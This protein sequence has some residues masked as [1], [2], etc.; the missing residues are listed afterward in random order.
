MAQHIQFRKY[1]ESDYEILK[2]MVFA[3]A[4]EDIDPQ[5]TGIAISKAKI[6]GTIQR[7]I[8]HPEQISIRIFEIDDRVAGYALLTFYWSNEYHGVVAILDELYVFQQYRSRGISTQF[9]NHLVQSSEYT[10]L[11]LE[12]FKKNIRAFALY[13]RMGFEV[14]D[15][16]FMIKDCNA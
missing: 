12:V 1:Q 3:L 2:K 5:E 9:I 14:V 6:K 10:L 15:R 8:T 7:S 13:Q 4:E 16:H 11:Q